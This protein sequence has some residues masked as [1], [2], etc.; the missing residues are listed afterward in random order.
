MPFKDYA[1]FA[2]PIALPINGKTYTIPPCPAGLGLEILAL[3]VDSKTPAVELFRRLL[4]STWDQMIADDVP[5]AAVS[6]AG[7]VAMVDVQLG[8]ESAEAVWEAGISPEAVAALAAAKTTEGSTPSPSTDAETS[9]PRRASM[10]GTTSPKATKRAAK[11]RAA[12][13]HE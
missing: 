1:E 5:L 4:G 12:T 7:L 2:E 3:E 10:S 11:K 6:R 13:A 9:T 8:R